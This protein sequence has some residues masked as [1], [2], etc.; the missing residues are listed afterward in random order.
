M[1]ELITVS[2]EACGGDGYALAL[3]PVL[4]GA[5]PDDSLASCEV[6]GGTGVLEVCGGCLAVPE[7]VGG[8]EV[9]ACMGAALKRAA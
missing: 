9:C 6:C 4:G 3:T 5:Q 1:D 8:F 7:V 2:C